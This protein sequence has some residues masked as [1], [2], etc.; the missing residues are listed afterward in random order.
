MNNQKHI[1]HF[2]IFEQDSNL[3]PEEWMERSNKKSPYDLADLE[4]I[5]KLLT[6]DKD[7][8][9]SF[10]NF[11]F[12]GDF[13]KK[14]DLDDKNDLDYNLY[15]LYEWWKKNK[16]TLPKDITTLD[17][18]DIYNHIKYI[19]YEDEIKNNIPKYSDTLEVV[20]N[21][22]NILIILSDDIETLKKFGEP[23][24][25]ILQEKRQ[26]SNKKLLTY[27]IV[28][29]F[30]LLPTDSDSHFLKIINSDNS[31]NKKYS[32][33]K[34][35]YSDNI[36]H[37][38]LEKQLNIPIIFFKSIKEDK[39]T[40]LDRIQSIFNTTSNYNSI[41]DEL[42]KITD[43]DIKKRI[44]SEMINHYDLIASNIL[45]KEDTLEPLFSF[46]NHIIENNLDKFLTNFLERLGL[47]GTKYPGAINQNNSF[48]SLH[49]IFKK[50]PKVFNHE[51]L[52]QI[53]YL[54]YQG[55]D[56]TYQEIL[57]FI[58]TSEAITN[59]IIT[60]ER[61]FQS[62]KGFLDF[63]WKWYSTDKDYYNFLYQ[64][65]FKSEKITINDDSKLRN[66]R[67]INP[68]LRRYIIDS[69][70]IHN[71]LKNS[72]SL[73]N[74]DDFR[75]IYSE[76]NNSKI[77]TYSF[78]WINQN[79]FFD[80]LSTYFDFDTSLKLIERFSIDLN[81]T[82]FSDKITDLNDLDKM[83]TFLGSDEK[84]LNIYKKISKSIRNTIQED[85]EPIFLN[86]DWN[87]ISTRYRYITDILYIHKTSIWLQ[88]RF[89]INNDQIALKNYIRTNSNNYNK[90][91]FRFN[92]Q[93]RNIISGLKSLISD[94]EE[95]SQLYKINT[96]DIIYD[97]EMITKNSNDIIFTYGLLKKELSKEFPTEY[98]QIKIFYTENIIEEFLKFNTTNN[99]NEKIIDDWLEIYDIF[100]NT[101]DLDSDIIFKDLYTNIRS[102]N[103]FDYT[104]NALKENDILI[105]FDF[106]NLMEDEDYSEDFLE[107]IYKF[108]NNST[109]T[110]EPTN[111][112]ILYIIAKNSN[113]PEE[114][115]L[116]IKS[117]GL[118]KDDTNEPDYLFK[119]NR[120]ELNSYFESD[121]FVQEGMYI[122]NEAKNFDWDDTYTGYDELNYSNIV[123]IYE[124]LSE[125]GFSF[126][127][128][129]ELL[130]VWNNFDSDKWEKYHDLKSK[131]EQEI[132]LEEIKQRDN[133]IENNEQYKHLKE[134]VKEI[135]NEDMESES[136]TDEDIII[137]DIKRAICNGLA[138]AQDQADQQEYVKIAKR[139][140]TNI[141]TEWN[142]GDIIKYEDIDG[143]E[144]LH[145]RIDP[146]KLI[147]NHSTEIIYQEIG[148]EFTME[149]VIDS[150]IDEEG[151]YTF[152]S[153]GVTGS[154]N[155]DDFNH[156]ASHYLSIINQ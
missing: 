153:R 99:I 139:E 116:F 103:Y 118:K 143:K 51:P 14:F 72:D 76:P 66:T 137:E 133:E 128:N 15:D 7:L 23:Y 40:E 20:H 39:K 102:S 37:N 60:L 53:S 109:K 11:H 8:I 97:L 18:N 113:D 61:T 67:T 16:D 57:F 28:W 38:Q 56:A 1:K 100:Y 22:N 124:L 146:F 26:E 29:D 119:S 43:K 141:F 136:G 134:Q 123:M 150:Y 21:K 95:Y 86:N 44:D 104:M 106:D 138:E 122:G 80:M 48:E 77:I 84:I 24:W 69:N 32:E 135:L 78:N 94:Y 96:N 42:L 75:K 144:E 115:D 30:N 85:L 154:I 34:E 4:K 98:E 25:E 105:D 31:L 83:N 125:A 152:D 93:C 147:D 62:V 148:E 107:D 130:S 132:R 71:K 149:N 5:K 131:E 110:P 46:I 10:L 63:S 55:V 35:R 129:E 50:Y 120:D 140:L 12:F 127:I 91:N 101:T 19:G 36:T 108:W 3:T 92:K 41:I 17:T 89:D 88:D 117:I 126:D 33:R 155:N 156:S 2:Q 79:F 111:D 52:R 87:Y 9:N 13:G 70:E 121:P 65:V 64:H 49:I 74:I 54:E 27:Y 112:F 90:R 45:S 151:R 47:I 6:N 81:D 58:I 73:L 114:I 59:E 68:F 145:L 142:D 82:N